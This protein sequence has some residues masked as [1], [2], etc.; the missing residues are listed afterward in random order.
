MYCKTPPGVLPLK[1][2]LFS[3]FQVCAYE[4]YTNKKAAQQLVV[5][6]CF[7]GKLN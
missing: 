1:I 6:V 5:D 4:A 7:Q 2:N 3:V